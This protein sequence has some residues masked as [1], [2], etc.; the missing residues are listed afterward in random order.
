[1]SDEQESQTGE[2]TAERSWLGIAV[3]VLLAL[4]AVAGVKSYHDLKV[5]R[6]RE[7]DLQQQVEATKGR[8]EVLGQRL[9]LLDDDPLTLE[10]LAREELGMV[11]PGDVVIVLPETPDEASVEAGQDSPMDPLPRPATGGDEPR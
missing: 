2:D 11:R 4:L 1:M 5:V 3:L 8:L 6:T 9:D 7:V 10:R